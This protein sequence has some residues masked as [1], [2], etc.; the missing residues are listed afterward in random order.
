MKNITALCAMALITL[1]SCSKQ[2]EKIGLKPTGPGDFIEYTIPKGAHSCDKNAYAAV[3]YEKLDFTVRFDS[4]AVYQ[5]VNT[6]NQADVNKLYGFAD[7]NAQHHMYSA[8]FGWRWSNGALRLFGYVYNNGVVEIKE[9]GIV[10]IGAD[11]N[12]FI[13]VAA[14]EYIFS[15]G[16]KTMSMP[17][18]STTVKGEGYKLYP[19]FGGD[20]T[21]PHTVKISIRENK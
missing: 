15:I 14:G 11:V 1:A 21:A 20:E 4:S 6:S 16:G 10:A 13:Q 2:M 17:R 8:R 12:C 3:Q 7:N 19:Y 5:T 9:L 18:A